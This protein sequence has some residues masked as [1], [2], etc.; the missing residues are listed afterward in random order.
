MHMG[1]RNFSLLFFKPLLNNSL[2]INFLVINLLTINL[3]IRR[4]FALITLFLAFC[5]TGVADT[6]S[7][8]HSWIAAFGESPADAVLI[9]RVQSIYKRV[10][11]ASGGAGH[12]SRLFIVESDNLPWAVALQD[13]NI[14]LTRGAIDVIYGSNDS[15]DA[16]DARMAFVLGHELKHV[17][18]NDFWHEE[19]HYS[20]MRNTSMQESNSRLQQRRR[21]DE[22]RADEEGFVYAS[23]A[24]FSTDAIF[25]SV[26]GED[27]FLEYWARQTD[28]ISGSGHYT[29]KQRI[30]FLASR[31][32]SLD[33]AVEYFKFGVRLAQFGRLQDARILLEEFQKVYPS[34]QVLANLGYIQL[35]LAR[36]VMPAEVAYRYWLPGVMSFE[37]GMRR[38][39]SRSLNFELNDDAIKHL[40]F[41]VE[42]LEKAKSVYGYSANSASAINLISAYMYLGRLADAR[43]VLESVA[44][45]ETNPQLL[46]LDAL[47]VMEDKR[48]KDPW[49]TYA[50]EKFEQLASNSIAENHLVYNYARLLAERGRH[51][52]AGS[53]WNRLIEKLDQL[54]RVYQIM[55]CRQTRWPPECMEY[56]DTPS[57]SETQHQWVLDIKP[58]DDI[59]SQITREKLKDWGEPLRETLDDIDATIFRNRNGN[60]LLAIDGVVELL[61]VKQHGFNFTEHLRSENG[62][63]VS[64]SQLGSGETVWSYGSLWSALV[65]GNSVREV[66]I[67]Q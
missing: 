35:Q 41:A 12:Q 51:G 32:R 24:G 50:R 23:L 17:L 58:G 26:G 16:Q 39:P 28:T 13:K 29:P 54:P 15:K 67:A 42:T 19:V 57:V 10:K 64:I 3:F 53:Y 1:S 25:N 47:M 20:L 46:S 36:K 38:N 43:A 33:A 34:D 49:N 5:N 21:N 63:P 9:R 52:Q 62:G 65:Y 61:S 18:D 2:T 22:L 27:N 8:A 48:L 66:W 7:N 45:W 6:R 55:V 30:E 11:R 60:S 31:Y 40:E 4:F 59:D 44:D 14:I 56:E 37:S